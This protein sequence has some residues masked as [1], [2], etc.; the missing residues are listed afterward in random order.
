MA[1]LAGRYLVYT[2]RLKVSL[3]NRR[4]GRQSQPWSDYLKEQ[5]DEQVIASMLSYSPLNIKRMLNREETPTVPEILSQP[6]HDTKDI[7][8]Y[9]KFIYDSTLSD[10]TTGLHFMYTGSATGRG[11]GRRRKYSHDHPSTAELGTLKCSLVTGPPPLKAHFFTM[12]RIPRCMLRT[13]QEVYRAY[14]SAILAESIYS[15][16]FGVYAQSV[17]KTLRME[18][19][20]GDP[21]EVFSWYGACTHLCLL[22]GMRKPPTHIPDQYGS[23]AVMSKWLNKGTVS[24]DVSST[25]LSPDASSSFSLNTPAATSQTNSVLIMDLDMDADEEDA[26]GELNDRHEE[27]SDEDDEDEEEDEDDD[28]EEE[29]LDA[30]DLAEDVDE[31]AASLIDHLELSQAR[32]RPLKLHATG[33]ESTIAERNRRAYRNWIARMTPAQKQALKVARKLS[34]RRWRLANADRINSPT[35]QANQR[36]Y[37]REY[38]ARE[39]NREKHN[40]RE[41]AALAEKK[42]SPKDYRAWRDRKTEKDRASRHIREPFKTKEAGCR[43]LNQYTNLLSDRC[44]KAAKKVNLALKNDPGNY[45]NRVV[46][47]LLRY[48]ERHR[49]NLRNNVKSHRSVP[50]PVFAR[51]AAAHENEGTEGA[52]A[53]LNQ[54]R[55]RDI[56][57]QVFARFSIAKKTKKS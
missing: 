28:E 32:T 40:A 22:E 7:V 38:R 5:S 39:G 10:P 42:K 21:D 12:L 25:T 20:Y 45:D 50:P 31:E 44:C 51:I 16:F 1:T 17:H 6:W 29:G 48:H 52:I 54:G 26:E 46:E 47:W 41:K 13:E 33:K 9:G 23:E 19:V 3:S 35:Y 37:N 11:G 27:A 24:T 15:D 30:A 4:Q 2:E 36:E 43:I 49:E 34:S 56:V 18:C 8:V 55:N 53:L 57:L 14:Q